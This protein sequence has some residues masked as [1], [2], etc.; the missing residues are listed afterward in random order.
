MQTTLDYKLVQ[1]FLPLRVNIL[2]ST[3]PGD[4]SNINHSQ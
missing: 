4:D 3:R 2:F 1:T